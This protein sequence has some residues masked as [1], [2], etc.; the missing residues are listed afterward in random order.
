MVLLLTILLTAAAGG[1]AAQPSDCSSAGQLVC[2][3]HNND[4]VDWYVLYKLPILTDATGFARKGLAYLH[5]SSA[6]A[7]TETPWSLSEVSIEDKKS[8][9]GRTLA[10]VYKNHGRE[11]LFYRFYNDH[12]P[13]YEKAVGSEGHT[14]GVLA[15]EGNCGFWMIHTVPR[16]PPAPKKGAGYRYATGTRPWTGQSFLCISFRTDGTD[17]TK[18]TDSE[19]DKIIN[20]LSITKPYCH[21]WKDH[22]DKPIDR[23]EDKPHYS[24]CPDNQPYFKQV[25]IAT[26][27]EGVKLTTFAKSSNYRHDL[28]SGLV[29]PALETDLYAET[30]RRAPFS[31]PSYRYP[32]SYEVENVCSVRVIQ[33]RSELD[34]EYTKD[35]SKWAVSKDGK[36][37]WVCIGDL[38]RM[39]TQ[40][41]RGGGT[42][43][44]KNHNLWKNFRKAVNNNE[45]MG[46]EDGG[47]GGRPGRGGRTEKKRSKLAATRAGRAGGPKRKALKNR[48]HR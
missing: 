7:S 20:Q 40:K 2:R 8:H 27:A 33:G 29:A 13:E 23:E 21:A 4:P 47:D 9:P 43:C 3:D 30:W 46:V 24:L 5:I 25:D 6:M 28:Y 44:L 37:P 48:R 35:H 14:K 18:G 36:E 22:D 31:L 38:N 15:H 19:L 32:D 11:G 45:C 39:E 34:F 16:F 10:P 26:T 1:W 41:R 17:A 12:W 42:A